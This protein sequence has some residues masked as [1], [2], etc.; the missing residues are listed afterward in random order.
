MSDSHGKLFLRNHRT[1]E[2]VPSTSDMAVADRTQCPSAS[3]LIPK[4]S[5]QWTSTLFR[6]KDAHH[7]AR[8]SLPIPALVLNSVIGHIMGIPKESFPGR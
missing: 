4:E 2:Q 5:L 7:R 8:N 6:L 1:S 3:M